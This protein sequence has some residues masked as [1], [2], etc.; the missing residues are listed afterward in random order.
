M[1]KEGEASRP[2][3]SVRGL[4]S[5]SPQL[6]HTLERVSGSTS[7]MAF[8]AMLGKMLVLL[9]PRDSPMINGEIETCGLC[10]SRA[11]LR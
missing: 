8:E 1:Q 4:L 11:S 2:V 9:L 3:G 5:L 7:H 6:Q 10:G